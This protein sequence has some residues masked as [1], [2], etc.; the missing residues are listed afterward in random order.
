MLNLEKLASYSDYMLQLYVVYN[1]N[2]T[3]IF[4]MIYSEPFSYT[5]PATPQAVTDY[6]VLMKPDEYLVDIRWDNY[7]RNAQSVMIALFSEQRNRACLL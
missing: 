4:D 1:D 7:P 2:G 3:D 6:T 5:N